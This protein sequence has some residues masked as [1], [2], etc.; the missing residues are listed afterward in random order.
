MEEQKRLKTAGVIGGLGPE[1]TSEFYLELVF[2]AFEKNKLQRP[3]VLIWSVPLDYEIEEE[4]LKNASGG[5]AY[6]PYLV[7]AA[8]RLEQGG[9][10]FLVMPCNSMHI[11]LREIRRSV[12]IPVLSV[13]EETALFLKQKKIR[14][15]GLLAT[16][17]LADSSIYQSA[18]EEEGMRFVLPDAF[19]QAKLGKMISKL[20]LKRHDNK[21][22]EEL[23]GIISNFESKGVK[24]VVLACT[25][26]QLLIPTHPKIEIFDTMKLLANATVREILAGKPSHAYSCPACSPVTRGT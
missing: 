3:P 20:V 18:L 6:I 25:D 23:F 4:F 10:D 12:G 17:A 8:K 26:L 14:E 16:R 5:N 22:R 13:I 15:V 9:A 1:T 21:D 19:E 11:H 2:G 7:D 24:N